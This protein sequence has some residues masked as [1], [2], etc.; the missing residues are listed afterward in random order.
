M[1]LSSLSSTYDHL[2]TTIMYGKETLELEDVRQ[3][4]QNNELMKKINSTEKAS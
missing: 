2:A 3:I 4:L 1:L